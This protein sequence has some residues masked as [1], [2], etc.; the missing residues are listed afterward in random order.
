MVWMIVLG[1]VG[2]LIPD[3]IRIVRGMHDPSVPAYVKSGNFYLGLIFLVA[4]GC[5]A[6]W[7][8]GALQPKQA[9]AYGY[10]APE[11]LTRFFASSAQDRAQLSIRNWWS[12]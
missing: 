6:A 12:R 9:L 1:G 2:G 11:L 8:L 10:G 3:V 7:L 5:L 4:L